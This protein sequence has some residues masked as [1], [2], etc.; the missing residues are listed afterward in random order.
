MTEID[1]HTKPPIKCQIGM[2]SLRRFGADHRHTVAGRG[3]RSGLAFH[4]GIDPEV[5]HDEHDDVSPK[6]ALPDADDIAP[7]RCVEHGAVLRRLLIGCRSLSD[8]VGPVELGGKRASG[9][10]PQSRPFLEPLSQC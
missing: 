3:E 8:A 2:L 4:P 6:R 9:F 7:L 1:L 10:L 5:G